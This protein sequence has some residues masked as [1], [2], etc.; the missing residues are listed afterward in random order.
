MPGIFFNKHQVF[1]WFQVQCSA[2]IVRDTLSL[3]YTQYCSHNSRTQIRLWTHKRHPKPHPHGQDME[4]LLWDFFF[5]FR[6]ITLLQQHCTVVCSLC[7]IVC[8]YSNKRIYHYH[9]QF[10]CDIL[11]IIRGNSLVW[12]ATLNRKCSA[13]T[14]FS[15]CRFRL[16][17]KGV[18]GKYSPQAW[19]RQSPCTQSGR[20]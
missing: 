1:I 5:F 9:K 11:A 19:A 12:S 18:R 16:S 20:L 15:G 7:N 17:G 14:R 2:I 13:N 6:K 4:C 8:M 10:S 3:Y